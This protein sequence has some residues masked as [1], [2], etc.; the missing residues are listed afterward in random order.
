MDDLRMRE[1]R[2]WEYIKLT[3][4]TDTQILDA[5]RNGWELINTDFT[6]YQFKRRVE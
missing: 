2:K 4:P 3:N 6:I 1:M 5:G